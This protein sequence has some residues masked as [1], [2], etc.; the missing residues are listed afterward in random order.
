[1]SMRLGQISEMCR[2]EMPFPSSYPGTPYTGITAVGRK[3]CPLSRTIVEQN[4]DGM[5][6]WWFCDLGCLETSLPSAPDGV[7]PRKLT[8]IGIWSHSRGKGDYMCSIQAFQ[9]I[10]RSL[11]C[12]NGLCKQIELV[13]IR[14]RVF[15]AAWINAG[16]FNNAP[17]ESSYRFLSN[18][19]RKDTNTQRRHASKSTK[20][21]LASRQTR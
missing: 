11:V 1:M 20:A 5:I 12:C 21:P 6:T 2:N 18:N 9:T 8:F 7:M 15:R 16:K 17:A 13:V 14:A 4:M 3:V 19:C 10:T